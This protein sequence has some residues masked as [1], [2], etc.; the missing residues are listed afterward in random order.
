MK[1]IDYINTGSGKGF[2]KDMTNF[3]LIKFGP[4]PDKSDKDTYSWKPTADNYAN[5]LLDKFVGLIPNYKGHN[6]S[7]IFLQALLA[8][9][10]GLYL[11]TGNKNE[12]L[13]NKVKDSD[14]MYWGH[15]CK[16]SLRT[17][18]LPPHQ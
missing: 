17:L 10:L 4:N 12:G 8:K 3:A 15:G 5:E 1:V 2:H 14:T 7:R 6:S 13:L 9:E 18:A 11:L 16:G